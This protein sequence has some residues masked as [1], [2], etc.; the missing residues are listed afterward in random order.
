[1]SYTYDDEI[2]SELHKDVYGCRPGEAGFAYWDSLTP[3][4]KQRHWD[5]LV[6]TMNEGERQREEFEKEASLKFEAKVADII[7]TGARDRET[8]IRWIFEAENDQYVFGDPDFFCYNYGLPYG[9]FK[10]VA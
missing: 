6:A 5:S 10:K 3:A 1:M 9:Y 2:Y 4:E 7:A 8:A